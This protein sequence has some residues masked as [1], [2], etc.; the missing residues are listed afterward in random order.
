MPRT[1]NVNGYILKVLPMLL[2]WG[3]MVH[4]YG[5]LIA[6]RLLGIDGVIK[7]TGL[8]YTW[9]LNGVQGWQLLFFLYAGGVLQTTYGVYNMIREVDNETWLSGL[10]TAL[11]G[12][13]YLWWEPTGLYALGALISIAL[14]CIIILILQTRGTIQFD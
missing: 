7:S 12:F 5:H 3:V 4:E 14:T 13:L 9:S 8:N 1:V 10:T 6:L 2:I 11:Q